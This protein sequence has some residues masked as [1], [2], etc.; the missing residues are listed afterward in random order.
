MQ[1]GCSDPG[2]RKVACKMAAAAQ[3]RGRR[4]A[5]WLQWP[6]AEEGGVQ[7]GC[8]GPGQ[9]KVACNCFRTVRQCATTLAQE[10]NR[11]R[12]IY[13]CKPSVSF[14]VFCETS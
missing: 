9:R 2:Q 3:G 5:K 4:R 8:S 10:D 14:T 7:N 1:N 13:L 12:K 6:R 11:R